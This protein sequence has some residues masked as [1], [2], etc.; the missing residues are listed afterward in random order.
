MDQD[1][2]NRRAVELLKH[3]Q[4][5]AGIRSANAFA[6]RIADVADG[7]P[8]GSAYRRWLNGDAV[9]PAWA[10]S[11]AA[12]AAGVSLAELV[13]TQAQSPDHRIDDLYELYSQLTADVRDLQQRLGT[14]R[15]PR[16]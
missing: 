8:S 10:I 13:G 11:A 12:E 6:R 15:T 16:Q 9:V 2:Y 4:R 3:A 7:S 14:A 5:H 1:H